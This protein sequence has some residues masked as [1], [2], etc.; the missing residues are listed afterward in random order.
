MGDPQLRAMV[1]HQQTLLTDCVSKSQWDGVTRLV[2]AGVIPQRMM[3]VVQKA[4]RENQWGCVTE[5]AT[6]CSSVQQRDTILRK[7]LARCQWQCVLPVVECGVSREMREAVFMKAA[8]ADQWPCLHEVI[9]LGVYPEKRN[10]MIHS[11]IKQGS[12]VCAADLI[13]LGINTQDK[14]VALKSAIRGDIGFVVDLLKTCADADL[15]NFVLREAVRQNKWQLVLELVKLHLELGL[16][17]RQ[18]ECVCIQAVAHGG[19]DCALYMMKNCITPNQAMVN[20]VFESGVDIVGRF[21][22][23]FPG[24]ALILEL[25][26]KLIWSAIKYGQSAT[27]QS[28]IDDYGMGDIDLRVEFRDVARCKNKDTL[29]VLMNGNNKTR[30][31]FQQ[32]CASRTWGS[33]AYPLEDVDW[34]CRTLEE[35]GHLHLA[36]DIGISCGLWEFVT[37]AIVSRVSEKMRRFYLRKIFTVSS[38]KFEHIAKQ[39]CSKSASYRRFL[40]LMAIR[41]GQFHMA[42]S[43]FGKG[44]QMGDVKFALRIALLE[45]QDVLWNVKI[46]C[47]KFK[48]KEADKLLEYVL[49]KALK[50]VMED[51]KSEVKLMNFVSLFQ[52]YCH[53]RDA[54]SPLVVSMFRRGAKA[55]VELNSLKC[56]VGIC[57]DFLVCCEEAFERDLS[58]DD[59]ESE[60]S[61]D[62]PMQEEVQQMFEVA[63][64]KQRYSLVLQSCQEMDAESCDRF[65]APIW[66]FAIMAAFKRRA[67]K[68][69][70]GLIQ[71]ITTQHL[72]LY[73][74]RGRFLWCLKKSVAIGANDSEITNGG[75]A[76]LEEWFQALV[77]D[78][79]EK[80]PSCLQDKKLLKS[81][82]CSS[83]WHCR[84]TSLAEWCCE[85]SCSNLALFLAVAQENW[86]LL[87]RVV[88]EHHQSIKEVHLVHTLE[89]VISKG[90]W[91]SA[92]TVLRY[93]SVDNFRSICKALSYGHLKPPLINALKE[94]CMYKWA[95]FLCIFHCDQPWNDVMKLMRYSQCQ[96]QATIGFVVERASVHRQW[97]VVK[98]YVTKCHDPS[99]LSKV[100]ISAISGG[101]VD[102][103]KSLVNRIDL[104][105]SDEAD[106]F[107]Q[108][109][110]WNEKEIL[111]RVVPRL[112][113]AGLSTFQRSLEKSES[114]G[115]LVRCPMEKACCHKELS[116]MKLFHR[117]GVCSNH[118]LFTLNANSEDLFS[119]DLYGWFYPA[120]DEVNVEDHREVRE[121]LE[122]AASVPL[123]LQDLSRQAV[124]H[125]L[126][127]HPGREERIQ[128]LPVPEPIKEF[129]HFSDLLP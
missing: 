117:S 94:A 109:A 88:S 51:S 96:D 123:S 127:C 15:T 75:A 63:I 30:K 41:G 77:F 28:I 120:V 78:D 25:R 76:V 9:K 91:S 32:F 68:L 37:D 24:R 20:G 44:V 89:C 129:L 99:L 69:L 59:F 52:M 107:L 104:A 124:S 74:H 2:K 34:I 4:V 112:I 56:F 40:F 79:A 85:N 60:H 31:L 39:L 81:N 53:E 106:K 100:L 115:R 11:A 18:M 21:L 83:L 110:N 98:K 125:C 12:V 105:P 54:V 58:D 13:R 113:A 42:A 14:E 119:D 64:K 19:W 50:E 22:A 29:Q 70:R 71:E 57:K 67:W 126:G 118:R 49:K 61:V 8:K 103:V 62:I 43:L 87:E 102:L 38:V 73:S 82:M 114:P 122:Q 95:L 101:D 66:D 35:R 27:L 33:I 26:R 80:T 36:L 48:K 128:A 3:Q 84:D 92:V 97:H 72:E 55:A 23:L 90:R 10:F 111:R 47:R 1:R 108:K 6:R 65:V 86:G 7:I 45:S 116:V 46:F 16:S 17:L 121:Y 93:L 5:I